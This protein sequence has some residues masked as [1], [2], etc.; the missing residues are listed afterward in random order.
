M[1]RRLN[2]AGFVLLLAS[3]GYLR[4]REISE[5][6]ALLK[7]GIDGIMLIGRDHDPVVYP[8]LATKRVPT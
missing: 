7:H 4:E 8:R 3:T 5:L 6:D 2:A 1:Q